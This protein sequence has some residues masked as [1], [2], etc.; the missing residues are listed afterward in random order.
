[1][2]SDPDILTV[3]KRSKAA[4]LLSLAFVCAQLV[5]IALILR[6]L[7]LQTSAFRRVVYIATCGF[8]VHHLLPFRFRLPFFTF[9]STTALFLVLGAPSSF[10]YSLDPAVA[11]MRGGTILALG[12]GFIAICH[13]P[14][15]FWARVGL[16]L[17]AGALTAVF[18]AR[19]FASGGLAIILP[20]LAACFM[21]RIVI[22]L[23]DLS[24]MKERPPLAQSLAYFF[25]MLNVANMLFPVIDFKTFCRTYYNDRP[26]TIYQRGVLWMTR[27]IIQLVIYRFI[28]QL[29]FIKAN[30]VANGTDLIQFIVS[31]SLLYLKVSGVFHFIVGSLLLFGFNLPRPNYHYFLASSFSDYWRR[32]NIYW[33]DFMM[34]IFYYP[35]VFKLKTWNQ[36]GAVIVGT[37]WA[38]LVTWALHVYQTWWLKGRIVIT[39][40]DGLFWSILGLLVV[41]NSVWE[42]KHKRKRK[43]A[44]SVYSLTDVVRLALQTAGTFA[45]ISLLWSLWNTESVSMWIGLWSYADSNT[46][47][48]GGAVLV[49]VMI[50]KLAV[51]FVPRLWNPPRPGQPGTWMHIIFRRDLLRCTVPLVAVYVLA[52]PTIQSHLDTPW[53]QPFRDVLATGDSMID[54]VPRDPRYYEQVANL[55]ESSRQLWEIF[56]RRPIARNYAGPDPVRVVSDF[57]LAEPLPSVHIHAYDTEF[58]TNRW[59]FRDRDYDQIKAPSIVRMALLGASNDMG[60][61]VRQ[62]EVFETIMEKRLNREFGASAPAAQFEILNFAFRSY[63]PLSQISVLQKKVATFTPD[64]VLFVA[65]S[66]DYDWV[67]WDL[68]RCLRAGIAI[69]D[70]LRKTL[71]DA[72]V[73]GST[74]YT[75]ALSR[76]ELYKAT[77]LSWTYKRLVVESRALGALPVFVF[78]VS[79]K[80]LINGLSESKI[81]AQKTLAVEA[82]FAA[83]DLSQIFDKRSTKDLIQ[84]HDTNHYSPAGHA[85]IADAFYEQLVADRRINLTS[86]AQAASVNAARMA[87]IAPSVR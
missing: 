70:V 40:P 16:L 56:L 50:V 3:R 15:G 32:A 34:K 74:H 12:A 80:D 28:D 4:D 59:G 21:F 19:I 24:T 8:L 60:W 71:S 36:T 68:Q 7:D 13:L 5:L 77:L 53:F 25:P 48:W 62:N 87:T 9:L 54:W 49:M 11:L 78:M 67:M 81:V 33:K 46:L 64:I 42:L 51:E 30:Q 85:L 43:L 82:G 22:Y 57:R 73:T 31:N 52:Q 45:C 14:I 79:P 69:P 10:E 61:G 35:M 29:L 37:L 38:F 47:L 1:M 84:V 58:Q 18:R 66:N 76:L 72:R 63:S 41:A 23:Y 83:L 55:D 20:V 17:A 26:V 27:G 44:T 65:H 39:W 75:F 6:E 2:T 86:R